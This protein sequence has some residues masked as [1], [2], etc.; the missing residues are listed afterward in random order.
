MHYIKEESID[1]HFN[2][3]YEVNIKPYIKYFLRQQMTAKLSNHIYPNIELSRQT[4]FGTTA[5]QLVYFYHRKNKFSLNYIANLLKLTAI[6]KL[7]GTQ[8][9]IFWL[10]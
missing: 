7:K 8:I 5:E 3:F 4:V 6:L 10:L 2:C 9:I 1:F